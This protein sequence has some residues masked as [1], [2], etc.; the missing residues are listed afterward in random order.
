MS[1]C[2]YF[3]QMKPSTVVPLVTSLVAS[4]PRAL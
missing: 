3:L 4:A 1:F 2:P